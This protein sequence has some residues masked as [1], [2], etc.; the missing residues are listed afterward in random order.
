MR[1]EV[2]CILIPVFIA[3]LTLHELAHGWV[4]NRLGDP[5][6]RLLG[7]LS[8]N[9][10]VHL[11]PL[12]TMMLVLTYWLPG[13][14][15]FGWAKPVPV[16]PGNLGRHV[17]RKMALIGAAGPATNFLIALVFGA[18]LA[19]GTYT[20]VVYSVLA[21]AV[22]VNIV[23]GVFNLLPI[24]PLD[25]S[26]IIGGFMDRQTYETWSG[27]DQYGMLIVLGGLI[28]FRGEFSALIREAI[29]DVANLIHLIVQGHP[30]FA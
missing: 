25:G 8:L 26:R 22:I 27:F 9:P 12:G 29:D 5:T 15:L 30:L 1:F 23:L 14:F 7:R 4:A 18:A 20:G 17:Q 13:G 24:P 10:I 28:F 21:Y 2:F 6:A 3:S 11:D 16:D 19:H